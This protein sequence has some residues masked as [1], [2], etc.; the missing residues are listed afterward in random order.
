MA[1]TQSVSYIIDMMLTHIG[2]KGSVDT[3]M[4]WFENLYKSIREQ[5]WE[6]NW[7]SMHDLTKAVITSTTLTYTWTQGNDFIVCSGSVPLDYTT[8]GRFVRLDKRTYRVIAVNTSTNVVTL[9]TAIS[10]ATPA[11]GIALS[12]YRADRLVPT[13]DIRSV[14]VDGIK[15]KSR[16][17][18]QSESYRTQNWVHKT[19]T[20]NVRGVYSV[21]SS[22]DITSPLYAPVVFSSAA[23]TVPAGKRY[24]FFTYYDLESKQESPPGPLLT[25]EGASSLDYVMKYG[26]PDNLS[27]RLGYTMRLYRSKDNPYDVDRFTAYLVAT[28]DPFA[29]TT[30]T[31]SKTDAVLG[32]GERLYDGNTTLLIFEQWPDT[33]LS[34]DI[35]HLNDYHCRPEQADRVIVGT[36]NV[37]QE[38]LA[39]GA[40]RF[41]ESVTGNSRERNSAIF[42]FRSQMEY[43]I[44][45]ER[46]ANDS[47]HSIDNTKRYDGVVGSDSGDIVDSWRQSE[48]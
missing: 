45:K 38:L 3:S 44:R 21:D 27:E 12:F 24:Y 35:V 18:S 9:D 7:E 11:T 23:G 25:V 26:S 16:D 13:S 20:S 41:T 39:L 5:P 47:D 15:Y 46:K 48:S 32:A 37:V 14:F 28:R 40:L 29:N 43:L 4:F 42:S 30:I 1:Q 34:F 2:Q 10:E 31:D 17:T 33:V 22:E 36:N 19:F 8:C 6:W